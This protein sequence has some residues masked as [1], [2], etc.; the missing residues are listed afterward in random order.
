[1]ETHHSIITPCFGWY[2]SADNQCNTLIAI[3]LDMGTSAFRCPA[4]N[5]IYVVDPFKPEKCDADLSGFTTM[6]VEGHRIEIFR[7]EKAQRIRSDISHALRFYTP[8]IGGL[9]NVFVTTTLSKPGAGTEFFS[10]LPA[11]AG[12]DAQNFSLTSAS[13]SN[14]TRQP[15]QTAKTGHGYLGMT[16]KQLAIL[17]LLGLVMFGITGTTLLLWLNF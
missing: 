2:R 1:M 17:I 8:K 15:N 13:R 9:E 6:Q 4:C 5:T 11:Q 16:R 12:T 3:A 7:G 10:K 14:G